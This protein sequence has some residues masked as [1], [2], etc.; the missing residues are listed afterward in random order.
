M[1]SDIMVSHVD[2]TPTLL[3]FAEALPKGHFLHGRS[4]KSAIAA[5]E[6]PP[7]WD[8]VNASHTFHEITM[9]Y[10]MRV[11]RTR[12]YKL[13]WNIAAPL[14]YPF[15]SDLWDAPTWQDAYRRGQDTL[16]GKRTVKDYIHRAPFE[17]YDLKNDPHEVRNLADDPNH[18][19]LQADMKRQLYD[20]QKQTADPWI[21]KWDYE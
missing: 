2:L 10:P 18:L 6:P 19:K 1:T 16:Y 13:I 21:L 5:E 12:D 11:V 8:Q 9:Y 14:P 7:G 17:L 20:F 3:D 15:A 4:W